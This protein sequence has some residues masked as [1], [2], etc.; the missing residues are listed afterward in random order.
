MSVRDNITAMLFLRSWR[1]SS[2]NAK[3][4]GKTTAGAASGKRAHIHNARRGSHGLITQ[5]R[6]SRSGVRHPRAATPQE[7]AVPPRAMEGGQTG[8]YRHRGM[9][10]TAPRSIIQGE[11]LI[12]LGEK[13]KRVGNVEINRKPSDRPLS[14]ESCRGV[15]PSFVR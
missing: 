9:E 13:K 3:V 12:P 14:E 8:S 15:R 5:G 6:P 1:G 2:R 11:G 10:F 4:S 7:C